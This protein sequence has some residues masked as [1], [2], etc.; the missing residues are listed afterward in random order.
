MEDKLTGIPV[1][2]AKLR[3]ALAIETIE[4]NPTLS[5]GN[6]TV[7]VNYGVGQALVNRLSKSTKAS[8]EAMDAVITTIADKLKVVTSP[9]KNAG[10]FV[11]AYFQTDSDLNPP[12]LVAVAVYQIESTDVISNSETKFVV[13]SFTNVIGKK[14]L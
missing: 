1:I 3:E 14:Y 7:S 5:S 2:N 9:F 11:D 13:D 4:E 6:V 10:K 12:T 8:D